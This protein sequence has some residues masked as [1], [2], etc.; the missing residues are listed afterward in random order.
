MFAAAT[1]AGSATGR[2]R[3][4]S[5]TEL[6]AERLFVCD[7]VCAQAFG[8]NVVALKYFGKAFAGAFD[9]IVLLCSSRLDRAVAEC[10]G[11]TPFFEFYYRRF[12]PLKGLPETLPETGV[13]APVSGDRLEAVA[14]SDARRL[15]D[16]FGVTASD[17]ILFPS[18]DF[19]GAL[20]LLNA[21]AERPADQRPFLFFRFIGVMETATHHWR[22][23]LTELLARLSE[24]REAGMR[25]S[26]SAETPKLADEMARRLSAPVAATS[27]P[28]I[29]DLLP[30]PDTEAFTVYCPGS[31]RHDKGFMDLLDVF[32]TVRLADPELRVRFCSQVL[33]D[34]DA[35]PLQNY[36]SQL[37][38]LPGV[39]LLA[40]MISE[41]EMLRRYREC[42]AVLM[43]YA[44]DVYE[45]RG[46]AVM[47][48]AAFFGRPCITLA[49][50]AFA[51]QVAFYGLGQVV[52]SVA[53]IPRALLQLADTPRPVL[54]ARAAQARHR[55]IA[56]TVGS[57]QAWLGER[58]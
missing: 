41:A 22:D 5:G 9:Q 32:R 23:P 1:P 44:V 17:T 39:E 46:S 34:R 53:D 21:L 52:N 48:E 13:D 45:F 51:E 11:F 36:V 49:G 20:G 55:L 16:S 14:T 40:P 28:S 54:Q 8:H 4:R 24:A 58:R 47:M 30:M 18:V 50:T 26:F 15:L 19:Y 38:A 2:R 27:Y 6:R 31:A 57:Y 29:L 33:T 37:Y 12:M 43:P 35:A 42:S 3:A 56:D 10:N 25:M 7:P